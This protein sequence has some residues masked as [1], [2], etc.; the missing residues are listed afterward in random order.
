MQ[1]KSHLDR[2]IFKIA[3][4]ILLLCLTLRHAMFY[5]EFGYIHSEMGFDQS[6]IGIF[7]LPVTAA[8]GCL[9]FWERDRVILKKTDIFRLLFIVFIPILLAYRN[10]DIQKLFTYTVFDQARRPS[11]LILLPIVISIFIGYFF[12]LKAISLIPIYLIYY[13]FGE[14][15]LIHYITIFITFA[16]VQNIKYLRKFQGESIALIFFIA[17]VAL[18]IFLDIKRIGIFVEFLMTVSFIGSIFYFSKKISNLLYFICNNKYINNLSVFYFYLS[19]A[20]IF[21]FISPLKSVISSFFLI[22]LVFFNS[23]VLAY[24]LRKLEKKITSLLL[25]HE[26]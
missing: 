16:V 4:V 24:W 20:L 3:S 10:N 8:F 25:R 19:Q 2:N 23:I 6:L 1:V 14:I 11:L 18:I 15:F 26:N 9:F 13:A 5:L 12:K 7:L 17:C 22:P 21:T